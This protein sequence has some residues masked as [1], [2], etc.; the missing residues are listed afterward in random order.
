M[1]PVKALF[2]IFF[3]AMQLNAAISYVSHTAGTTCR[4]DGNTS[5]TTLVIPKTGTITITAGHAIWAWFSFPFSCGSE[6]ITMPN[7][8]G[9]TYTL[10]HK[11][12]DTTNLNCVTTWYVASSAGGTGTV[13]PTLSI[14]GAIKMACIAEI[15]GQSASPLDQFAD[16]TSAAATTATIGPTSTTAAPNELIVA[17]GGVGLSGWGAGSGYTLGDTSSADT[18]WAGVEFK[19]VTS[20]GA[21]SATFTSS[22]AYAKQGGM[23]TFKDISQPATGSTTPSRGSVMDD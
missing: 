23:A 17:G 19:N 12:D 22:S 13:T 1:R 6:V 16:M 11:L 21:Y 4:D 10:I 2:V 7:T 20:T 9:D 5:G 8:F 15:S 3:A 18:G 14:A